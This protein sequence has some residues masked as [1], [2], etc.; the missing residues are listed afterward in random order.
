MSALLF[1][2]NFDWYFDNARSQTGTPNV[3]RHMALP[4]VDCQANP[5]AGADV[6]ALL[7]ATVPGRDAGTFALVQAL[8]TLPGF[9]VRGFASGAGW[10]HLSE[11]T[12]RWISIR[13]KIEEPSDPDHAYFSQFQYSRKDGFPPSAKGSDFRSLDELLRRKIK[14]AWYHFFNL[15]HVLCRV[16]QLVLHQYNPKGAG[17]FGVV[18]MFQPPGGA[19]TDSADAT[20]KKYSSQAALLS[21]NLFLSLFPARGRVIVNLPLVPLPDARLPRARCICLSGNSRCSERAWPDPRLAFMQRLL[22]HSASRPGQCLVFSAQADGPRPASELLSFL[23]QP[24]SLL[25]QLLEALEVGR[26]SW[27]SSRL[28]WASG[29]NATSD[30]SEKQAITA[31]T[32]AKPV[33]ACAKAPVRTAKGIGTHPVSAGDPW[34]MQ[35][36]CVATNMATGQ[37]CQTCAASIV[38]IA[39]GQNVRAGGAGSRLK[40]KA[41]DTRQG[42][43]SKSNKL[44]KGKQGGKTKTKGKTARAQRNVRPAKA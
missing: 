43:G 1:F 34:C 30:S 7:I 19:D 33:D 10:M 11:F 14:P 31:Q 13:R 26:R 27:I 20:L 9:G 36:G 29:R 5:S 2:P 42:H 22:D 3:A 8:N 4:S 37:Q 35:P 16:R 25:P 41:S 23:G 21:I 15:S 38:D 17:F 12:Q 6:P 44:A 24:A 40:S 39:W 28:R 18:H 32:A